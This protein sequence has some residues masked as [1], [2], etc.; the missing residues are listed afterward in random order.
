MLVE[1]RLEAL[2]LL[3]D[4]DTGYLHLISLRLDLNLFLHFAIDQ[5]TALMTYKPYAL[6]PDFNL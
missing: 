1:N 6:D 4:A 2:I 3:R 5:W